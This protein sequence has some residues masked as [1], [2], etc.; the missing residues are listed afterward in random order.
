MYID[1]YTPIYIFICL[2]L[3]RAQAAA[4][5]CLYLVAVVLGTMPPLVEWRLVV[6]LVLGLKAQVRIY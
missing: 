5:A 2:L 4:A 3:L 1:V 6:A